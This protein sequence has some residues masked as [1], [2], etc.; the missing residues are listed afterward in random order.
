MMIKFVI[1]TIVVTWLALW[2]YSIWPESSHFDPERGQVDLQSGQ[3]GP[4]RGQVDLQSGQYGPK[5]GQID[6]QS[7]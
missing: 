2:K 1:V 4:E 6:F 7:G 5:S 3:Y